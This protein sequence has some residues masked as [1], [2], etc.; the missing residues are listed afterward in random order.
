MS[1]NWR[2]FQWMKDVYNQ[3]AV[4]S[5]YYTVAIQVQVFTLQMA[6][7]KPILACANCIWMLIVT[8]V[9]DCVLNQDTN[10]DLNPG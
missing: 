7:A 3:Q 8:R 10:P 9:C 4:N 5:Y 6:H 2:G 1:N